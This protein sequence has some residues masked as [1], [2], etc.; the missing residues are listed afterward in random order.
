M[1]ADAGWKSGPIRQEIGQPLTGKTAVPAR[2]EVAVPKDA[3]GHATVQATI[4]YRLSATGE[5]RE[6]QE[7]V[8]GAT[9][10]TIGR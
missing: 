7:V 2:V 3:S 6:Y 4:F 1:D 10:V 9:Q 8:R 5:G